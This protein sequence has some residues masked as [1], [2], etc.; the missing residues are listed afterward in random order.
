MAARASTAT[1][2]SPSGTC[3]RR[4][5]T[6]SCARPWPS[7]RWR[8]SRRTASATSRS[9]S[10]ATC[11]LYVRSALPYLV[12]GRT[13]LITNA[14]GINPVAAGR[15]V[16]DTLKAA[17]VGGPH[18]GHGGG[19]RRPAAGRRAEPARRHPVRQ[20]LPRRPADRGGPR[21]RRRHHRH[22]PGRRRLAVRRPARPRARLGMGRLGPPVGR[23]GGRA[24]SSSAPARWPA[25]TTPGR[26]GRTPTR[27]AS[28]SRSARSTPTARRSSPS[29]RRRAAWSRSTRCASSCSTRSTIPPPT[30]T[31]TPRP[32]SRPS[33]STD[34]GHDRVRVSGTRGRAAPATYKGLVCRPA[35]WAGEATFAY[36]WPDAEAKARAAVAWVRQR[37]E[38]A[39]VGVD[40]WC[41]EYFGVERLPRPGRRGGPRRAGGRRLRASRGDRTPGLAGGR[42]RDRRPGR[43]RA[44]ASWACRARPR[45]R[46]SA[47]PAAASRPSCSPSRP[48]PWPGISSTPGCASS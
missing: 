42:P 39:G 48:S 10:R 29:R 23:G 19:R 1:A 8:S 31:P 30:S 43:R 33:P 27:C 18:R 38:Q 3:S 14:G 34:L 25:A 46:A 24:T 40:E 28:G 13:K 26:G 16:V 4:A 45:S 21:R 35:G 11:P 2:C 44:R 17:G 41:E 36:S 20:R 47:G 32:T 12:D 6:T 7:S 22:R 15:A 9:A 5:S 37:A